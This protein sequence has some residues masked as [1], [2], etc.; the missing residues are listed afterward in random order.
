M[1]CAGRHFLQILD[2]NGFQVPWQG[3]LQA[4]CCLRPALVLGTLCHCGSLT[5]DGHVLLAV[6][7]GAA[8]RQVPPGPASRTCISQA[9]PLGHAQAH[10]PAHTRA[11]VDADAN[12]DGSPIWHAHLQATKA[13]QIALLNLAF[14]ATAHGAQDP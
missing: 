2:S 13:C 9:G 10:N 1:D 3:Y 12:L 11:G 14:T 7:P 4:G 5:C 6:C 8:S